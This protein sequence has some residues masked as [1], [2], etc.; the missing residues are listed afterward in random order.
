MTTTTVQLQHE[1]VD[2]IPL[3]MGFL[4]QMRLPTILEKHLGSHHLHQGI[5]NGSLMCVWLTFILSEGSH[6]K[7]HVQDWAASRIHI[8]QSLLKQ[9][10]RPLECSDDRLSILL[11]RLHDANWKDLES[12]LWDASCEVYEIPVEQCRLDATTSYGYHTI[13][14]DGLM[15]RGHSKDHR[16]DLPQLKLMAAAALPSGCP[17][18]IDIVPGNSADDPLYLPL[19]ARVRDQLQRTGLLYAG[20]CKMAAIATRADIVGHDDYYLTPLPHTGETQQ[21]FANWVNEALDG[22]RSLQS[23]Y[24]EDEETKER[25]LVAVGYEFLRTCEY[26]EG[27]RPVRWKER[28]Q[29]VRSLALAERKQKN[30]E[31][32]LQC[33]EKDIRALTPPIG[34]GRRQF[35]EAESL[36]AAVRRILEEQDV[37]GLLLV[38]WRRDERQEERYEGRGRGGPNRAK[39]VVTHVRYQIDEVCRDTEALEAACARLGWRAQ[40]TNAPQKRLGLWGSVQAYNQGWSLER[41]FHVLKDRPLGIQP[42]HVREEEQIEGLTRLLIIA[43]RVLTLFELMVRAK[44]EERDEELSGLYTGQAKRKTSRPTAV[45]LLRAVAR[46]EITATRMNGT[47]EEGWHLTPLPPLLR[48]ILE[49]AGLPVTLYTK[50][51]TVNS[52]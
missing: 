33:A 39:R 31:Q 13:E 40:V 48:Q 22:T 14:P 8:L 11:R 4:E 1:R 38:S 34:R 3:L 52:G 41:D 51:A 7:V 24:H 37:E 23:S 45:R 26:D 20:D 5:S 42:L 2:D 21:D 27:A 43:L 49:L 50:L 10:F 12:N 9:E 25:T 16:P 35:E 36:Q 6:C 28:V 19:I 47:E 30:L 29:V 44:L 32:R 46:M 15:Q 18:A 17:I